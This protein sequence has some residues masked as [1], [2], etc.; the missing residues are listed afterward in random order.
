MFE[1]IISLVF[2]VILVVVLMCYRKV[3]LV[4][5]ILLNQDEMQNKALNNIYSQ[6]ESLQNIHRILPGDFSFPP[7]RGWSGSPD[8]LLHLANS[9][10][11]LKPQN[12][13][14]CGCGASTHVIAAAL[15]KNGSGHAYSLEHD[16]SYAEKCR[17]SLKLSNLSSWA[18]VIYA[19]LK[20]QDLDGKVV[21]WYDTVGLPE[22]E[23]DLINVDGPPAFFGNLS[24]YPA[25]PLLSKQ[26][27]NG[28]RIFI[29]DAN[30]DSERKVVDQWQKKFSLKPIDSISA[31]KGLGVFLYS[32]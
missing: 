21:N 15:K 31:E 6:F 10:I 24:R 8:Y 7:F 12:T 23:I 2:L 4:H 28:A 14:E 19:P 13:V 11:E 26:L 17:H 29:D 3:R 20:N 1:V 27:N 16:K 25:V 9:I 30:R 32:K 5:L 22:V 18:T